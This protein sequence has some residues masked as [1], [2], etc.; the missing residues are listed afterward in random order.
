MSRIPGVGV[1]GAVVAGTV[2]F[3]FGGSMLYP[4]AVC[5]SECRKGQQFI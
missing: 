2:A 4:T 3:A 1:P 5:A